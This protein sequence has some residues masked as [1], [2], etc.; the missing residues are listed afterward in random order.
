MVGYN[1]DGEFGASAIKRNEQFAFEKIQL[2]WW[3]MGYN[4][5]TQKINK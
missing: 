1:R 5:D 2:Q 4:E 3:I